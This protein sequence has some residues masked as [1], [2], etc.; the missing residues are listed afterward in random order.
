M[1]EPMP[2]TR[3]W[4]AACC[5]VLASSATIPASAASVADLSVSFTSPATPLVDDVAHYVVNVRNGGSRTAASVS[6]TVQLPATHTS[7][8]VFVMGDLSNVDSRCTLTGTS[9]TC[10]LASIPRNTTVSVGFDLALPYSSAPHVLAANATTTTA[11]NVL[12]NNAAQL[13]AAL[14][15]YQ[16]P[17]TPP[18]RIEITSCTGTNLTSFFECTVYSGATQSG[19]F[20]L[21]PNGDVTVYGATTLVG[22]WTQPSADTLDLTLGT[23]AHFVGRGVDLGCFEGL[24]TRNS[25]YVSPYRVCPF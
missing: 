10:N 19:Q 7:P 16:N 24:T 15:Y 6:L 17:V 21:E 22:H 13:V 8:G 11:E 14:S 4:V 3:S 9:L 20:Q 5:A 1:K 23:S 18:Q 25:P 12:S 2:K